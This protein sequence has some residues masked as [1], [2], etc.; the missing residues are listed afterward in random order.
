MPKNLNKIDFVEQKKDIP[1]F[2]SSMSDVEVESWKKLLLEMENGTFLD[3]EENPIWP[4]ESLAS[5]E[6]AVV[7]PVDVSVVPEEL[8]ELRR[9]ETAPLEPVSILSTV[10]FML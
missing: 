7:P 4:L 2:F 5:C 6:R 9:K 1:K 8:Y 3:N 10:Q